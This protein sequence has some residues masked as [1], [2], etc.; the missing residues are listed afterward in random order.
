MH[1][2]VT[3]FVNM[4]AYLPSQN[5]F[6][7]HYRPAS[8]TPYKWR[9]AGVPKGNQVLSYEFVQYIIFSCTPD[10]DI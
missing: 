6:S 4:E 1:P 7:G 2:H 3:R 10:K 9:F 8:Q 5:T